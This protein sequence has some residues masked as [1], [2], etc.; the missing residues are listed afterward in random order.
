MLMNAFFDSQFSYCP[1]IWMF[2]KRSINAK[3][4]N[5]QFRAL[6]LIYRDENATFEELLTKDGSV[7]THQHNLQNL[8]I[9]MFKSING[10]SSIFSINEDLGSENVSAHTR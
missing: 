1:L 2:H 4:N 9:E 8:A 3:I 5:I 6:R 7:T 10:Q